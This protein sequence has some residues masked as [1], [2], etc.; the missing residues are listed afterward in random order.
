M[1]TAKLGQVVR[2]YSGAD[3]VTDAFYVPAIVTMTP[4]D[5]QPGF[6]DAQGT[7]VPMTDHPQPKA[8]T[9]H[10]HAF[11]PK[12]TATQATEKDFTD[13]PYGRT[14]GCWSEL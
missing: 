3:P 14:H 12:G 13:V 9:V 7:W 1:T 5:W 10:L 2:Y 8:G 11:Y 6:R 4:A